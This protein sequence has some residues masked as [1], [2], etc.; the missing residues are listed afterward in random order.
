VKLAGKREHVIYKLLK[1]TIVSIVIF[2]KGTAEDDFCLWCQKRQE[3]GPLN[4]L[5]EFPG[6]KVEAGETPKQAAIREVLEESGVQIGEKDLSLFQNYLHQYEDRKVSLFVYL[7]SYQSDI[8]LKNGEWLNFDLSNPL[9]K[10]KDRVPAANKPIL[11]DLA[12][13]VKELMENNTWSRLWPQS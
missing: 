4:G 2:M 9:K 7:S 1:T 6:G 13:Y 10:L 3:E 11:E 8:P 12:H 5:L